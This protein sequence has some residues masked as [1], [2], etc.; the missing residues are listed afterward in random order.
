[1]N[2]LRWILLGIG[3]LVIAG[4]YFWEV[5]KQKRYIRSRIENYPSFNHDDTHDL[6]I[7]P[8]NE[9]DAD[10]SGAIADLNVFL[11]DSRQ[12]IPDRE[13]LVTEDALTETS[14]TGTAPEQKTGQKII[15]LFITSKEGQVLNGE[16]I[17]QAVE[18]AGMTFG[19][20]DIYHYNPPGQP[21]ENLFS[22]AN[23]HE[24]GT[25]DPDSASEFTTDGLAIFL[26]LPAAGRGAELFDQMLEC[27]RQ[28]A[29]DLDADLRNEKH[30][31]ISQEELENLRTTAAQYH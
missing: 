8:G 14:T 9:T 26:C 28:I 19:A 31:I 11:N 6:S 29:T 30:E 27:A 3:V 1:M 23:M 10:V 18:A 17:V 5:F 21:Q 24:P 16:E 7:K 20:M 2:E 22:L 13:P 4:I 12:D 15:V 25:F